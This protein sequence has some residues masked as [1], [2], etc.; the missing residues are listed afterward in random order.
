MA[1]NEH[2]LVVEDDLKIAK[3]LDD[4][5]SASSYE[6]TLVHDG[7]D[8]LDSVDD[9]APDLIILDVML[10]NI[11]GFTL[12]QEIRKTSEIP[13]LFLTARVDEIDRLL[14]LG[15]GADDYVTKPF[16][17]REVLLRVK[18]ILHRT[19]RQMTSSS[20][21]T[22][23][24]ISLDTERYICKINNHPIELTPIEFKLLLSLVEKPGI[25]FSRDRLM[26]KCYDDDRIVN[27]RTIDS[28][29]KNVRKKLAAHIEGEHPV[30]AVYGVG[31]KLG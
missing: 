25:V 16:S 22:Y 19:S 12:C 3:L 30:K 5:L 17:V 31:Y 14:G 13:I 23:D 29:M 26:T 18:N 21:K 20:I 1:A 11:D 8:V 7:A 2:I 6:T 24:N 9:I 28:H 10:P 4:F 27:G 15:S